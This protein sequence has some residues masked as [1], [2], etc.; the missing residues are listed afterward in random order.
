MGIKK[1]SKYRSIDASWD[2]F[3]WVEDGPDSDHRRKQ[4]RELLDKEETEPSLRYWVKD[5]AEQKKQDRKNLL[6]SIC[7]FS[8]V[9]LG[10]MLFHRIFF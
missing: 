2:E 5:Y 6:K 9:P 3:V 10:I 7:V 1:K 4:M 8:C